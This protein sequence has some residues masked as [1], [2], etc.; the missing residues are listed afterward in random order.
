MAPSNTAAA[1]AWSCEAP[2]GTTPSTR[3]ATRTRTPR[4]RHATPRH[5]HATPRH[6]T[7]RHATP[8]ATPR[9]ATP[10]HTPRH[11]TPRHTPRHATPRTP[12]SRSIRRRCGEPDLPI[13]HALETYIY[14]HS[15]TRFCR[16]VSRP[17]PYPML[18]TWI[19]IA[20]SYFVHG[21]IYYIDTRW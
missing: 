18:C 7:P 10:R 5:A 20:A 3:H 21:P 14:H 6:A 11:A 1:H 15:T 9:H 4:T 13:T 17:R 2:P 19:P 16:V 12:N 8:H